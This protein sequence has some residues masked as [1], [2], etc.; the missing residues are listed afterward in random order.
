MKKSYVAIYEITK[1]K[2][3]NEVY[4]EM[5]A[6]AQATAKSL[7]KPFTPTKRTLEG[8]KIEYKCLI[9]RLNW[10]DSMKS[11]F[12]NNYLLTAETTENRETK[13]KAFENANI[14]MVSVIEVSGTVSA[15][16]SNDPASYKYTKRKSMQELLQNSASNIQEDAMFQSTKQIDDFKTKA[17]VLQDYPTTAK[18]GVKEGI[19]LDE[20]FYI[21]EIEENPDGSQ[22]KK[23]KA[24]VRVKKIA[25]NA[26]IAKG[27]SPASTFRQVGGRRIY[28]GMLIE[29]KEDLGV[30]ATIAW[31]GDGILGALDLRV[32]RY[33]KVYKTDSSALRFLRGVHIAGYGSANSYNTN[34]LA[35]TTVDSKLTGMRTMYGGSIGKEFFFTKKGKMYFYPE[36]GGALL[37]YTNTMYNGQTIAEKTED[38]SWSTIS[39]VTSLGLG[40]NLSPRLSFIFKPSIN[41]KTGSFSDDVTGKEII[42]TDFSKTFKNMNSTSTVFN[43][44]L[45]LR[46]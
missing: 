12:E 10:S 39:L 21:Y 7:N 34:L 32:D 44:G 18:I 3:M 19:Y 22:K 40:I 29:M 15:T 45:R 6:S 35:D 20:Q 37:T 38:R 36:I 16:Q 26:A 2:S 14:P 43:F 8:Y 33:L 30:A 11:I 25:D 9:Y 5:D 13:I 28:D 1:V 27:E 31:G 23:K 17:P 4:N 41:I 46:F 42:T 24:V